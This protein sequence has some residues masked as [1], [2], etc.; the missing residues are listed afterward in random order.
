M[1]DVFKTPKAPRV[2]TPAASSAA[3]A[4]ARNS[5]SDSSARM[6]DDEA[7]SRARLMALVGETASDTSSENNDQDHVRPDV[8]EDSGSEDD[9]SS[10]TLPDDKWDE[11]DP[12]H[13][14]DDEAVDVVRRHVNIDS[15][16]SAAAAAAAVSDP[17][18]QPSKK[19]ATNHVTR[20][21]HRFATSAHGAEL[22]ELLDPAPRTTVIV[23]DVY[24]VYD[25]ILLASGITAGPTVPLNATERHRS[26]FLGGAHVLDGATLAHINQ[27][28]ETSIFRRVDRQGF[29]RD[30]PR[31]EMN[32]QVSRRNA[33]D[34][35][36][37][38]STTIAIEIIEEALHAAGQAAEQGDAFDGNAALR[39]IGNMAERLTERLRPHIRVAHPDTDRLPRELQTD[40]PTPQLPQL[41]AGRLAQSMRWSHAHASRAGEVIV[42]DVAR[43]HN[44]PA[45]GA[46]QRPEAVTPLRAMYPANDRPFLT[47]AVALRLRD[48]RAAIARGERLDRDAADRLRTP[49]RQT[50]RSGDAWRSS[51]SS[52][53]RQDFSGSRRS[54]SRSPAQRREPSRG[55]RNYG[56][57]NGRNGYGQRSRSQNGQR[58]NNQGGRNNGNGRSQHPF[59]RGAPHQTRNVNS[60]GHT[61]SAAQ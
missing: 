7:S 30:V 51:G 54:R 10:D 6:S 34:Q 5:A 24:T 49:V 48:N 16:A 37:V 36:D 50:R 26:A 13:A 12:A 35:L 46:L 29:S 42:R 58:S 41:M 55:R 22:K 43:M 20:A 9:A 27:A 11:D 53:R 40:Q 60:D 47:G 15:G 17:A 57:G 31:T 3:A 1:S 28:R 14:G 56:D 2:R 44:L 45:P 21:L 39:R 61:G 32:D 23:D 25:E 59:H 18:A 52:Q 19:P 8:H 4:A 33:I 38:W